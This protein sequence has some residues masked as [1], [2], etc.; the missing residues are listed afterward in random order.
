MR[1]EERIMKKA[2]TFV[3]AIFVGGTMYGQVQRPDSIASPKYEGAEYEAPGNEV[4]GYEVPGFLEEQ[5]Q[6]DGI[7]PQTN[8]SLEREPLP[9][10]IASAA[11]INEKALQRTLVRFTPGAA[12]LYSGP[13]GTLYATGGEMHLPGMMAINSGAL[14][15]NH[16]FGPLEVSLFGS[17]T[18]YGFFRGLETS[19]GFGGSLS[20]RF[21]D[22]WSIT[23]FGSY[24]TATGIMP[25]GML[26]YVDVPRFGGYVDYRFADRWGIR[27]GAQSYRTSTNGRWETQPIV[28]PYF[29][30]NDKADIGIDVGGILYQVLM[31]TAGDKLGWNRG[32]P[33]MPRPFGPH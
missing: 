19:W 12:W 28:M 2:L 7:I 31:Q 18:K 22:R 4:P 14:H 26:G 32:N 29:K 25:P 6:P 23:V 20:Y 1:V 27:V 13:A 16:D 9:A 11:E 17:A 8:P 5:P 15:F 24:A 3:L 10:T 30:I 21:S 33:T